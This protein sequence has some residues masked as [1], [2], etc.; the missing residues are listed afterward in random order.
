[1]AVKSTDL[2]LTLAAAAE[3]MRILTGS[4]FSTSPEEYRLLADAPKARG[5]K[6]IPKRK[7]RYHA[8]AEKR[9]MRRWDGAQ[10]MLKL[11]APAGVRSDAR[12][13]DALTRKFG[14]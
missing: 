10:K 9:A 8:N 14:I 5:D 12:A 3:R 6:P 11:L 4:T 13:M 1:M 2:Y 7:Q